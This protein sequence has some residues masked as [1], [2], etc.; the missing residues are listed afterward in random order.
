MNRNIELIKKILKKHTHEF[1]FEEQRKMIFEKYNY[2]TFLA[3]FVEKHLSNDIKIGTIKVED[4]I[5]I[6]KHKIQTILSNNL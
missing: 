3:K 4:Y 6:I 2:F 5:F 1:E